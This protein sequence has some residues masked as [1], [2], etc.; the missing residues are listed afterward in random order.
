MTNPSLSQLAVIIPAYNPENSLVTLVDELQSLGFTL[1]VVVDDGS[2]IVTRPVFER[3]QGKTGVE[4]LRHAVNAGKG[5]ALKT[6]FNHCLCQHH[7]LTGVITADADGQHTP[8]DIARVGHELL[9]SKTFVLGTRQFAKDVPLRSRLGNLSTRWVVSF[10]YGK[11]ITDT[12]TGLRGIANCYL[13]RLL[14]L[15][16][17]RYEYET[18]MLVE[19]INNRIDIRQLPIETIYIDGNRSSHFNP[20]LDSMR[21]YFVLI[22]FFTS[23]LLAAAIDFAAFVL[24]FD[25]FGSPL[26]ALA[27]GRVSAISVN[28][29][30]NKKFVFKDKHSDKLTMLR[31]GTV[32]IIMFCLSYL[33]LREITIRTYAGPLAAKIIA[34]SILFILSFSIQRAFVFSNYNKQ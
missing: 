18:N 33:L 14:E 3:L 12:Q 5:R 26:I 29:V 7:N 23:S 19:M 32:V 10:L 9:K 28:Y 1:I 22:R 34:E 31:Y 2:D 21:I 6:A 15:P 8:Q 13:T 16:G 30:T 24:A 20:L 4:Q 25:M 17:E 11:R 27:V